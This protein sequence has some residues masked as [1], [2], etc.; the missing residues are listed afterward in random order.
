MLFP[1]L[2]DIEES[3]DNMVKSLTN[4]WKWNLYSRYL[5]E[6]EVV[7]KNV[8]KLDLYDI[9]QE[10]SLYRSDY[11]V[12]IT[13]KEYFNCQG[14]QNDSFRIRLEFNSNHGVFELPIRFSWESDEQKWTKVVLKTKVPLK[15]MRYLKF[16]QEIRFRN[17]FTLDPNFPFGAFMPRAT[18]KIS[19]PMDQ[20]QVIPPRF[21]YSSKSI[22]S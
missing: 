6:M 4:D 15:K 20:D 7:F 2:E 17:P 21:T 9:F 8:Q 10:K 18:V 14:R 12:E 3:Q 22:F 16:T 19:F 13:I 11:Q 1:T 5:F